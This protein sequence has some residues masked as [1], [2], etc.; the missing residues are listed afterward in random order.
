MTSK[1]EA[2]DSFK[3][4]TSGGGWLDQLKSRQTFTPEHRN[5]NIIN[6]NNGIEIYIVSLIK[7]V[8]IF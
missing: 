7:L 8:D 3:A 1:G 4:L 2:K 5:T 6:N